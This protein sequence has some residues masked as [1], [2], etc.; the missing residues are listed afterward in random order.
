MN[1]I[2]P[3][4]VAAPFRHD[5][6]RDQVRMISPQH[7]SRMDVTPA[8]HLCLRIR[9]SIRHSNA[10]AKAKRA[11]GFTAVRRPASMLFH[12][13]MEKP[14]R[15]AASVWVIPSLSRLRLISG[16]FSGMNPD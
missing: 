13:W 3:R 15:R 14:A 4:M 12:R 8:A 5:R 10:L 9:S 6:P 16:T 11:S 2:I 7:P 1:D